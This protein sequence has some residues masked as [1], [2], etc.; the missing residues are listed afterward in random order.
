MASAGFK[1]PMDAT[2]AQLLSGPE[3][4]GVPGNCGF[5]H[6]LFP[7]STEVPGMEPSDNEGQLYI[8]I[9]KLELALRR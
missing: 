9:C 1:M 2:G 6:P 8:C 5:E 3:G 4:G 7:L